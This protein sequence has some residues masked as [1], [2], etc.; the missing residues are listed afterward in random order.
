M[1][2]IVGDAHHYTNKLL[3]CSEWYSIS[4]FLF[5]LGLFS[6]LRLPGVAINGQWGLMEINTFVYLQRNIV[7]NNKVIHYIPLCKYTKVLWLC[8]SRGFHNF[9]W[10]CTYALPAVHNST[11]TPR[12]E[13]FWL[14]KKTRR[15]NFLALLGELIK[16]LF[17]KGQ[18]GS[19][20]MYR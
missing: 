13:P 14:F 7:D 1:K 15:V 20:M 19:K 17:K 5:Q 12:K 2:C 8:K 9:L 3:E 18:I 10:E 11:H 6:N 4:W 16:W